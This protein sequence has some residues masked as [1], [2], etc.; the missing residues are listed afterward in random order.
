MNNRFML[1]ESV[2]ERGWPFLKATLFLLSTSILT[3]EALPVLGGGEE[4]LDH[5]GLFVLGT[6]VKL[7]QSGDIAGEVRVGRIVRV[8]AQVAEVSR[9]HGSPVE[10]GFLQALA[11]RH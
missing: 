4:R 2:R 10:F 11:I 5:F 6:P 3:A 7:R 8:S 9:Q 1:L